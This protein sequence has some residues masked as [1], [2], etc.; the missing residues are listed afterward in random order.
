MNI[1]KLICKVF[2]NKKQ[3]KIKLLENNILKIN[4]IAIP[5]KG[6]A[7]KALIEIISQ[8]LLIKKYNIKIISGLMTSIKIIEVVTEKTRDDLFLLLR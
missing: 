6:Q 7:N 5:K 1:L 3:N 2:P 4:I 8:I